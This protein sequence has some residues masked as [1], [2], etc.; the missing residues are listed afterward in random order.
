MDPCETD[1]TGTWAVHRQD[2]N[3]NHF[4]VCTGLGRDDA[5]CMAAELGARGHKQLYWVEQ[6]RPAGRHAD[7]S[8]V[9][10]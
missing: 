6:D 7:G 2:D 4:V 1:S 3:G 5:D 10:S 8:K 9:D